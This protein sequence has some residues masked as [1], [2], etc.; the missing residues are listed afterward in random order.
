MQEPWD[1]P[2]T[3]AGRD[4]L[5]SLVAEYKAAGND[6]E[7]GIAL[8]RLAHVV[9]HVGAGN[10]RNGFAEC[11]RI[12]AESVALL[13]MAGDKKELCRA[14]RTS[15]VKFHADCEPLLEES[16]ELAQ[17][18]GDIEEEAWTT[19]AMRKF[20]GGPDPMTERAL[21]LFEQ[22]GS[23]IGQAA[24]YRTLGF[25]IGK[26]DPALLERSI[27]L[28]EE[29]GNMVEAERGRKFLEV[30]LMPDDPNEEPLPEGFVEKVAEMFAKGSCEGGSCETP[31]D[32]ERDEG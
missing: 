8:S 6:R 4:R 13:R 19:F 32:G 3:E 11:A 21:A 23:L 12:G 5:I 16:L 26:H 15:A 31:S 14:L 28:Y 27:Q 7:A 10:D 17:E 29:A 18:I 9:L 2:R 24:C 20:G 30:A 1:V 22:C 25:C